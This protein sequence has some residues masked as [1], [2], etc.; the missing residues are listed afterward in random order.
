[1]RWI[2]LF[3]LCVVACGKKPAAADVCAKL[4]SVGVAANCRPDT[5]GGIGAAA[6]ERVSFD[7]PSVPR[8]HGQ[9]LT[10]E[11]DEFYDT[12]EKAFGAAAALAGRHQYGKRAARVFVQLNS[13]TP[14]DVAQKAKAVVDAL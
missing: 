6:K 9:V 8:E 1:M 11:K 3:G 13:A 7:L 12:T 2:I 4:V 5:P 10:F 14:D